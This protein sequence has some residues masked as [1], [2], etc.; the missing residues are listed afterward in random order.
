MKCQLLTARKPTTKST[1]RKHK[2]RSDI[3]KLTRGKTQKNSITN[4]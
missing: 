3:Y 2:E 1:K 4:K